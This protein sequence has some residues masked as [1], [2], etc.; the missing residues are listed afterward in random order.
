MYKKKGD[1]NTFAYLCL[2]MNTGIEKVFKRII[3]SISFVFVFYTLYLAT[4]K[5]ILY[6]K[7]SDNLLSF[8][9]V[10]LF[11]VLF[12]FVGLIL[13]KTQISIKSF[14][15]V[16]IILLFFTLFLLFVYGYSCLVSGGSDA[17][18]VNHIAY[19]LYRE[20]FLTGEPWFIEYISH[21]PN[22]A[23]IVLQMWIVYKI[24]KPAEFAATWK[25][26]GFLAGL[27]SFMAICFLYALIKK[28]LGVKWAIMS[29]FL[30]YPLILLSEASLVF[31]TDI[32]VLWTIPASMFFLVHAEE[33][34]NE[35]KRIA[36][37]VVSSIILMYGFWNKPTVAIVFI[38]LLISIVGCLLRKHNILRLIKYIMIFLCSAFISLAIM[39]TCSNNML[40]SFSSKEFVDDM[41]FPPE[42][43]I[44]MGLN[45]KSEGIWNE[46]DVEETNDTYGYE[47]K[48]DLNRE[49][50]KERLSK[51]GVKGLIKH[52]SAKYDNTVAY[53]NF[54]SSLTVWKE[55]IPTNNK[56][57]NEIKSF[58]LDYGDKYNTIL[59]HNQSVYIFVLGLMILGLAFKYFNEKEDSYIDVSFISYVSFIGM[60]LF[61]VL[62]ESNRRYFYLMVPLCIYSSMSAE[63]QIFGFFGSK[64]II[65]KNVIKHKNKL[66]GVAFFV[67]AL[68]III[69]VGNRVLLSEEGDL[70]DKNVIG[71]D[72]YSCIKRGE[73]YE[74]GW[75]GKEGDIL[76][77]S[78]DKGIVYLVLYNC[79]QNNIGKNIKIE[80]GSNEKEYISDI[81]EI[82]E[83]FTNV[84]LNCDSNQE[85][86]IHFD[87]NDIAQKLSKKD[88]RELSL[89]I[90]DIYAE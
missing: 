8:F 56:L 25:I 81:I 2:F 22:N 52:I 9:V 33:K 65:K 68:F 19:H 88:E 4:N 26:T 18:I 3:L 53:G 78:K 28:K 73:I 62:F 14:N 31:Y 29:L 15:K 87:C 57:K 80:Y 6:I 27:F 83:D 47:N 38:A 54:T 40:Y 23:P 34:K 55:D 77:K 85:I 45:Q 75:I 58:L 1:A 64:N 61:I 48:K 84:C 71:S 76:I 86:F 46:K 90:S 10:I 60:M 44:A 63:K 50:I 39:K 5:L 21:Y 36:S 42:Q 70:S 79:N 32:V 20:D 43:F 59:L 74:D 41:K 89:I 67:V 35:P 51:M 82:K 72:Y 7:N 11:A 12:I 37:I 13:N 24:F 17:Y 49:K 69:S 66:F 16:E 30:I